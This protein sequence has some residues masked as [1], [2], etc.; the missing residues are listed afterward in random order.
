MYFLLVEIMMM[1]TAVSLKW[2]QIGCTRRAFHIGQFTIP[3]IFKFIFFKKKIQIY[4][5]SFFNKNW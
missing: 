3:T 1:Y 5:V 2:I 4:L